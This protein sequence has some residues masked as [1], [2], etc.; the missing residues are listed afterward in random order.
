L[1][2]A[3]GDNVMVGLDYLV[4]GTKPDSAVDA[5]TTVAGIYA[6]EDGVPL[7]AE[8]DWRATG[9]LLPRDPSDREHAA[10]LLIA[11]N[12]TA[13]RLIAAM[14][15]TPFVKWDLRWTGPVAL[16]QG[17]D[18]DFAVK[19]T[20][21]ELLN[22]E[23]IVGRK[24]A[25]A[26]AQRVVLSTGVHSFVERSEQAAATLHPVL[27]SIALTAQVMS[28][29]VLAICIWMLTRAR[30]REHALSMS[31]GAN[32]FRLGVFAA[33]EQLVPIIAGVAAAYVV[34]RW[35]P[36]LVAGKGSIDHDT[37]R[38]GTRAV[39]W[40]F[41]IAIAAVAVAGFAAVWPL[42]A[43]SEG[44]AKRVAGALRAE[45]ILVVA[46]VA[47]GA[48]IVTQKGSVLNSGSALLFPLLAVLAGSVLVV[49]ISAAIVRIAGHRHTRRS[50]RSARVHR[51]RSLALWMAR[52]RLSYSLIELSALVIV[53]SA[54]VGLFVYCTSISADGRRGVLD[55]AA[56]VGGAPAT[57][58]IN[59]VQDV[60][61]GADG[62]P[63]G[64]PAGSTVVWA[65]SDAQMAPS[66][67]ADILV[68]DPET[69]SA[70]AAWRDSF[71][72]PS[73]DSLLKDIGDSPPFTVDVVVAGNYTDTFPNDG[74]MGVGGDGPNGFPIRYHVVARV[75]AAPWQRERSSLVMVAERAIAMVLLDRTG[76]FPER[77][78][79]QQLDRIFRTYV[80]SNDTQADL[81]ASLGSAVIDDKSP[82][83]S[84]AERLPSFVAFSLSL[85]YLRLVGTALLL[86]SL[87]SI[88]V[89]G[90]RRRNDLAL[91]MALTDKMG[92]RRRTMATAVASG[93]VLLG[94]LAS[95]VGIGLA[96]LLVGF[97]IHR[98]DPSPSFAPSFS[99]S[100][101]PSAT[102][103]AIGG[104]V[105]V[106]LVAAW[107]ELRGARRARVSEVLRGAE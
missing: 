46:A 37:L 22:N 33:I 7:S 87:G 65:V 105:V 107:L 61:L 78:D 53:V 63:S 43:A 48:Q 38:R 5:P 32:P 28:A 90:A 56:A 9:S 15:D 77:V 95:L 67:V 45:T 57:A 74:T 66:V 100:L 69:F 103:V 49:R 34:V 101:S 41:P 58:A 31:M 18:V 99:G 102:F 68:V 39:L 4:P 91:E 52:R 93:A 55:K 60:P 44:R 47:T 11:D 14:D 29:M 98:L 17:R 6:T 51:P 13:M 85:P 82:N 23:S 88:V 27:V 83:V 24:V 71:A 64:L 21:D 70:A 80:W 50:G 97:M 54:G 25:D 26:H 76:H 19:R 94:V 73:L 2:I 16:E 79:A 1:G 10:P 30:R 12:G 104:V 35:S 3:A 42:D 89:L 20:A 86:V 106:S 72:G 8:F 36:G 59:S 96:R 84:I 62:F 81:E 92:M 75:A 40:A